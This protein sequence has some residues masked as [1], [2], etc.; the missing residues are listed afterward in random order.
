MMIRVSI[1]YNAFSVEW[2]F[3]VETL[4]AFNIDSSKS[5][6]CLHTSKYVQMQDA[7]KE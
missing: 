4:I 7:L 2:D 3:A 6:K 1:I 5:N